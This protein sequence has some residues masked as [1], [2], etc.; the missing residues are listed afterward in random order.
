MR[1]G[2]INLE[3]ILVSIADVA[4]KLDQEEYANVLKAMK[5]ACRLV[6]ELAT[7]KVNT[8]SEYSSYDGV[9]KKWHQVINK[10]SILDVIDLI[11]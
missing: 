9:N 4:D 1:E 11:E 5:E 8:I 7:K 2:K 10:Q 6:L 3:E